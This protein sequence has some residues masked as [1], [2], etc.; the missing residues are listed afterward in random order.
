MINPKNSKSLTL[1]ICSVYM[2]LFTCTYSVYI[3]MLCLHAPVYI[4]L[5]TCSAYM[6]RLHAPVINLLCLHVL[7]MLG[8]HSRCWLAQFSESCMYGSFFYTCLVCMWQIDVVCAMLF[9]ND[10]SLQIFMFATVAKFKLKWCYKADFRY[11]HNNI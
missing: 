1:L 9:N 4:H 11:Q 10:H 3:H 6:L 5:S 8:L 7:W 2:H